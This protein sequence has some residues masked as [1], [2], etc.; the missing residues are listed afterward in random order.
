MG[1]GESVHDHI[2]DLEGG[3]GGEQAALKTGG[4]L[5]AHGFA[6]QAVA[7]ERDVQFRAQPGES[8]DMIA[9]FMG[10][11]NAVEAFRGTSDG[12]EALSNLAAAE[13]GVNEEAGVV[14]FQVGAIPTGTAAEDGEL[15]G[16]ARP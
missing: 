13:S 2:P 16:H 15:D 5:C 10:E 11:Q 9:V 8:L 6:R 12:G 1:Y 14:G 3:P 4:G 7:V